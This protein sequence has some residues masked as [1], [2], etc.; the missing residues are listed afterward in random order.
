MSN[1]TEPLFIVIIVMLIVG[2]IGFARF[3]FYSRL[4]KSQES[5]AESLQTI[6]EY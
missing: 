1:I 4:L 2:P 5:I 6:A 3:K